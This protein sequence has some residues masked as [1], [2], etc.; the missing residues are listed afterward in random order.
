[1]KEEKRRSC[2][3]VELSVVEP[4]VVKLPVVGCQSSDV[5]PSVVKPSVVGCQSSVVEPSDVELPEEEEEKEDSEKKEG[6]A[7]KSEIGDAALESIREMVESLGAEKVL[8]LIRDN[9]NAAIEQILAELKEGEENEPM[10][11]GLSVEPK[12]HS[13]FDLAS[14]A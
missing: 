13:I 10:R 2:P 9:R 14:F 6:E 11:S 3:V 1:M 8:Q 4:S 12:Y 5:K 7:V